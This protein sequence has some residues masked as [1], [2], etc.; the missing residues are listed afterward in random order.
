MGQYATLHS[1][2]TARDAIT[3]ESLLGRMEQAV[4]PI[5]VWIDYLR[6]LSGKESSLPFLSGVRSACIE[7]S[8]CV[9]FGLV[10]PAL[11]AMRLEYELL[12]AWLYFS[13]HPIECENCLNGRSD[14]MLPAAVK[15]YLKTQFG[16]FEKKLS[17]L[18]NE[19][20][21]EVDD[22]YRLLSSHVHGTSDIHIPKYESIVSL[23]ANFDVCD[24]AVKMQEAVSEYLNDV[25]LARYGSEW[26]GLPDSIRSTMSQRL[27]PLT[28]KQVCT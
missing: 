9:S 14:F 18:V 2:V 21:R 5:L 12:L 3:C 25:L 20:T 27:K 23:I 10:R 1:Y 6:Q 13:D 17:L 7:A 8:A 28:L 11:V 22:P 24:E 19:K 4:D 26:A 15:S 16:G